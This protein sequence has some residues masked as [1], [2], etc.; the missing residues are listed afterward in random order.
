MSAVLAL[1][2]AL[3]QAAAP[4]VVP[5]P[6]QA[7]PAAGDPKID[8]EIGPSDILR[9]TVY[10]HEDLT[11]VVVVQSDGTFMFPL[12]GRVPASGSTPGDL[13]QKLTR[14]LGQG[15]IRKPEV[16]VV[17]QEF[18]SKNIYVMGAVTHPGPLPMTGSMT[19]VE[20]LARA[21]PL[22]ANAAAEIVVVRPP[23]D[24]ESSGPVLPRGAN[25]PSGG[26]QMTVDSPRAEVI[27]IN[28]RDIET[29][30]LET[31]VALRPNDTVF[32][33][34]APQVFVSGEVRNP[35]AFAYRPGLSV[36]Q[37]VSMAGGL[38]PEGT[39]GRLRVVRNKDGKSREVKIGLD[40]PIEPGDTLVIRRKLF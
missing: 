17:V 1:L 30:N 21:G 29:G 11:Q 3:V 23:A 10:G 39:T 13:A 35:G 36:R 37:L 24:Q 20:A 15:Y 25:G 28:L 12:V 6:E 5:A 26:Q 34:E 4:P 33:P 2:L 9:V 16:S 38:T 22:T 18:K 27:R 19:L 40:D 7:R 14:L 31:N 8:Y 32:V